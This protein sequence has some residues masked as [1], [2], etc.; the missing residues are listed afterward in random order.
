MQSQKFYIYQDNSTSSWKAWL[1]KFFEE[2]KNGLTQLSIENKSH[3]FNENKKISLQDLIDLE[4]PQWIYNTTLPENVTTFTNGSNSSNNAYMSHLLY[5]KIFDTEYCFIGNYL[6]NS[7]YGRMD[8]FINYADKIKGVYSKKILKA[9]TVNSNSFPSTTY[10]MASGTDRWLQC[11]LIKFKNGE[12]LRLTNG[13][14]YGMNYLDYLLGGYKLTDTMEF[15]P[16]GGYISGLT[17]EFPNEKPWFIAEHDAFKPIASSMFGDL[18]VQK[19]L[20][21][22]LY[23]GKYNQ[24]CVGKLDNVLC[25]NYDSYEQ[26]SQFI[27]DGKLYRKFFISSYSNSSSISSDAQRFIDAFVNVEDI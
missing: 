10:M 14:S 24:Y 21:G 17:E 15:F 5:F 19:Y 20:I 1:E 16:L 4:F 6:E 12:I 11:E 13:T 18:K 22:E 7:S 26:D 9:S 8:L 27:I 3:C 23:Y 25:I 2:F